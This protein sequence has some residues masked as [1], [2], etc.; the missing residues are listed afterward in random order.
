[1]K[2]IVCAI[3]VA[4]VLV[5]CNRQVFDFKWNFNKAIVKMPDGT[6]QELKVYKWCDYEGDQIQ[7]IDSKG[8][9]WLFHAN[10]VVLINE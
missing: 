10:N 4:V 1:M 7:I 3:I 2:K 6:T 9:T 8:K 5:G